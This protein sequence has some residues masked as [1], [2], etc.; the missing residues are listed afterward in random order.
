[1]IYGF[2]KLYLLFWLILL[3]G[4]FIVLTIWVFTINVWGGLAMLSVVPILLIG[5][6]AAIE[7]GLDD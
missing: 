4:V 1:M 3:T 7:L 6:G 2:I 5:T